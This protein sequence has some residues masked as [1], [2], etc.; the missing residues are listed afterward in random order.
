MGDAI[1]RTLYRKLVSR[2]S[3]LAWVTAAQEDRFAKG[4]WLSLVHFMWPAA[5]I[6]T[7]TAGAIILL[8]ANAIF[9]ASPFLIVWLVS[10][11]V[12]YRISKRRSNELERL[13][14][15]EVASV[16]LLARRTWR[17]FETFVG[18]EDH[19][20]PLD[21]YQ[22]DPMPAIA[23]RT[24]PTN[25]GLF[26]LG[27]VAA[28]DFGYTGLLEFVERLEL[29]FT[30]LEK[31][32][33]FRGHFFNWYDTH[34]LEPLTPQYVS[35][36]DSGNLAGHLIAVKQACRDLV[37]RPICDTRTVAGLAD[38]I[39]LIKEEVDLLG[40]S[41]Q[42]MAAASLSELSHEIDAC[43]ELVTSGPPE[44]L[45]DWSE[46]LLNLSG[47]AVTLQDITKA[48]AYEHGAPAFADLSFWIGALI[49][50]TEALRRDIQTLMPWVA[51]LE[52]I[53][54][55]ESADYSENIFRKF[56]E[57]RDELNVVA[58]PSELSGLCEHFLDRLS[59]MHSEF[60]QRFTTELKSSKILDQLTS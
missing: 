4:D 21:N 47:N 56:Q 53:Q 14:L 13:S 49:H 32:S 60:E 20:L 11:Y 45:T 51:T 58:A 31:L 37:E 5:A 29:T 27:T 28:R 34:S 16:R 38:T 17:F 57:F 24:S 40:K 46:V 18:E 3:L 2:R 48:L 36:V 52:R 19:W 26:L 35:T 39:K 1:L 6:A 54:S 9:V 25:V 41:R 44:T 15:D 12:A 10:P 55:V 30:T 23:H 33:R 8:R 50:Q 43:L 42:S 59:A 7:A 22:E